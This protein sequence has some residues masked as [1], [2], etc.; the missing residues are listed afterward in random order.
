MDRHQVPNL[1]IPNIH[2][3]WFSDLTH[4]D[5]PEQIAFAFLDSDY[6]GS[7]LTS[8]E[9]IRP[10][11]TKGSLVIVDDYQNAQLPGAAKAVDTWLKTHP[12]ALRVESSLAIVRKY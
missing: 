8:L 6:Y 9:L 11:L 2:K 4:A 12:A 3:S 5:L 1:P 10:R 7:V